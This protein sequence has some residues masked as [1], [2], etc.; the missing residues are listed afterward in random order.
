VGNPFPFHYVEGVPPTVELPPY[1]GSHFHYVEVRRL[2]YVET[3]TYGG[4]FT[5]GE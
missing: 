4:I 5:F 2:H 1:G 3:S